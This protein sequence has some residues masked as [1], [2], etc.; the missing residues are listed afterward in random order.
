M[1]VTVAL[2]PLKR[3]GC[4]RQHRIQPEDPL[5]RLISGEKTRHLLLKTKHCMPRFPV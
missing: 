4:C 5:T 1:L 2:D 3:A